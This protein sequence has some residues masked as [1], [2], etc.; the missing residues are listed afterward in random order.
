MARVHL[1]E[2]EDF[3]WYPSALR[4]LE[5]DLLR[6]TIT[7][8][9]IYDRTAPL[10]A[11]CLRASRD[12]RVVDLCSGGAGPWRTLWRLVEREAG[13][14]VPVTLSD[15]FPN[16]PAFERTRAET[17]GRVDFRADPLD[18]TAVPEAWSGC[19][20]TIFSAFHHF[21]PPLATAILRDAFDR[22]APIGVFEGARRSIAEIAPILLTPFVVWL[23]V[24]FV[25]PWRWQ[26]FLFTYLL[27]V[28]PLAALWDGIVSC[29]RVYSPAELAA[30]VRDLR[31]DDYRWEIGTVRGRWGVPRVTYLVGRPSTRGGNRPMSPI[32]G[33]TGVGVAVAVGDGV[34]SSGTPAPSPAPPDAHPSVSNNTAV[35]ATDR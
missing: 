20:R 24:P 31:A 8:F 10:V 30:L 9:G 18:A 28:T 16:L 3:G 33:T 19:A 22:R 5:T 7:A 25:R 27:P 1:F 15:K 11:R 6:W 2:W 32:G 21:P 23:A 26:R 29:L 17:A 34:G 14:P 35:R 12:R 13:E 4:D